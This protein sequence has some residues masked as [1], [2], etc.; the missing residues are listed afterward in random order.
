MLFEI[1]GYI[2]DY[3]NKLNL[4]DSDGYA[5]HLANDY[6]NRRKTESDEEIVTSFLAIRTV[7][8]SSNA[9]DSKHDFIVRLLKRIDGRFKKKFLTMQLDFPGGIEAEKEKFRSV[10][11]LSVE[12]LLTEFVR[13]TE[14]RAID[15]FWQSRKKGLLRRKPEKIGQSLFAVF[16]K[17]ALLDRSG[18]I[19]REFQSGIGFVDVGLILGE[20]LNVIE[21]KVVNSKF[22][23]YN[24]LA[25]YMRNESL[26]VGYL[27]IFDGR[28]FGKKTAIPN[29]LKVQEG[30]I[31][32]YVGDINPEVPS[33]MNKT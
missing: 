17:G 12:A 23:G 32:V 30:I 6:F 15:S 31:N 22:T 26:N 25:R 5:V 14:S 16:A 33:S 28:T 19:I 13:A 8:F 3:F 10:P 24:Q 18:I 7:F 2:Q 4:T 9:I 11:D 1:Q 29:V 27:L 20:V 21:I